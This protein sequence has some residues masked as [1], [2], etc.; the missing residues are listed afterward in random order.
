MLTLRRRVVD[1]RA[2]HLRVLAGLLFLMWAISGGG[3]HAAAQTAGK[4]PTIVVTFT[5][6]HDLV[7][8]VAG[9]QADL[10][11]LV[12]AGAEVHEWELT[13]RNF[14]DLEEA[15][16]VFANGLNL[17]Q[18]IP[19]ARAVAGPGVPIV[20]VA[21]RSGVPIRPIL[22]GDKAGDPDPH[23]WMDARAAAAYVEAVRDALASLDPERAEMYERNA[24][25][26][27]E[28]LS[29][30]HAE[31]LEAFAALPPQS[32]VL[33]TSE[34]AFGYFAAAYGFEHDGI[35][36]I[37]AE[38]EGTPQQMIRIIDIVRERRP[39]A[40]FWESTV[41]DQYVRSVA[42][43]TKTAVA[44]PL[45]V[46]SLPPDPEKASYIGMM[47]ANTRL[48]VEALSGPDASES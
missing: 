9:P 24:A 33:I 3:L 42:D 6:L 45:F 39:A 48:L 37:N 46:D 1:G 12:P 22:I 41:S 15:D 29:A 40:V 20:F 11:L 25:R 34:A 5:V 19:Q 21:E 23:L 26:F 36:G 44:G 13:P 16:I 18:W 4:G 38:E 30:L 14:V 17:E 31:M 32:R 28:E 35:W 43:E 27:S 47:R 8:N 7:R 2:F 10:R